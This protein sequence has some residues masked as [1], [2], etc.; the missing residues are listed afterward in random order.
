MILIREKFGSLLNYFSSTEP[1]NREFK[2]VSKV[3]WQWKS[4]S[5]PWSKTEEP[6]WASYSLENNY[7]IEKAYFEKRKEV[8][9]EDYII[10]IEHMVQKKKGMIIFQRPIRRINCEDDDDEMDIRSERHFEA[11]LPKSINKIFGSLAHFISFFSKRNPEILDLTKKFETVEK[12]NDLSGLNK[13][14]LPQLIGCLEE[15][16]LKPIEGLL[17]N[18]SISDCEKKTLMR[19]KT[20]HEALILLFK[21]D[22]ESFEEFY[23]MIL[24][25]YTMSTDLYLNLN[26]YLRN[27]SWS[28]IDNLLPSAICLCKAFFSLKVGRNLQA[29]GNSIIL[30]RGTAL[31]ELALSSYQGEAVSKFFSWNS[32]TSTST[33]REMA[34]NFMYLSAEI[35]N[36]R[37]PVLFIIEIPLADEHIESEYLKWID[38]HQYSA[39]PKEDEVILPPGSAF[40]LEQISRDENKRTTIKIKLKHELESLAHG[41]LI[42]QGALQSEMM[43]DNQVK[44]MCLEG[45]EL[46]E[47]LRSISGNR[48]IEKIE[49]CLCLFES[50]SLEEMLKT[51]PTLI[52]VK[53]VEFITC[54]YEGEQVIFNQRINEAQSCSALKV[55]I[56]EVQQ[57][58]QILSFKNEYWRS[59][60]TLNIEFRHLGAKEVDNFVLQGLGHLTQLT[61]LTLDFSY[62]FEVTDERVKNLASQG[63][64]RL[65]QL[66]SLNLDFSDCSKI[67]DKGVMSLVYEGIK[68]L[69]QLISLTL[70]FF[71]CKISVWAAKNLAS[72]GLECF[73]KLVYLS[74]N[75]VYREL[76]FEGEIYLKRLE[77]LPQLESFILNDEVIKQADNHPQRKKKQARI[78]G[79]PSLIISMKRETHNQLKPQQ[80]NSDKLLQYLKSNVFFEL[81]KKS[82]NKGNTN[83]SSPLSGNSLQFDNLTSLTLDFSSSSSYEVTNEGIKIM[84]SEGFKYLTQLAFL[85]L[86]FCSCQITD[87]GVNILASQG[88]KYLT[89][90]TSLS[91]HFQNCA[92]FTD[93]GVNNL[94][95]QGL[96][97]LTQLTSLTLSFSGWLEISDE[98]VKNLVSEGLIYLIQL[99][100]LTLNFRSCKIT[101]EG[102]NILASQ[103]LKSLLRL[104]SLALNFDGCFH[105][106]DG[107]VKNLA[108]QGLM[109]LTQLAFLTLDFSLCRQITDEGVNKL[110]SQGFKYLI[111]LTSL[112]LNF[113]NCSKVTD[114]GVKDLTLQGLKH[115]V[116][117]TS[118]TLIFNSC[119][120]ITDEGVKNIVSQGLKSLTKLSFLA[121][122]FQ[123]CQ[124]ITDEGVKNLA[125][126]LNYLPQL[127]SVTLKLVACNQITGAGVNDIAS[128][129]LK[130]LTQLTSLTLDFSFCKRISDEGLNGLVYHI[131]RYFAKLISLDLNF[132]AC[133]ISKFT[134]SN[135]IQVLHYFG[136]TK[137]ESLTLK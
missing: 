118:L 45:E 84:A 39:Q 132:S 76:S 77:S 78:F 117:L 108:S 109:H 129:G 94:A 6:Q 98:G 57:F 53:R 68:Y 40:Q 60:K 2:T 24:R 54:K 62:C 21:K 125:E 75:F 87:E 71:G 136:F 8:H 134:T 15:E 14:I 44:I 103:G 29:K 58:F 106:T 100:S 7:L 23:G 63:L 107:A 17:N 95:S 67:S 96:K 43:S 28:A 5:D 99:T 37:Y 69:T 92:K 61:S 25:S 3:K 110:A 51:L 105:V 101:E 93:M 72:Q 128:L 122:D 111:Q 10:S 124:G 59:L 22:F 65:I 74:L 20:R 89:Q 127:A 52:K 88:L 48:L 47:A 104:T 33:S 41:G 4:N 56:S 102:V 126:G 90:L 46:F 66:T 82:I 19:K 81:I 119:L 12:S 86:S 97:D 9:L 73:T 130:Y 131:T 38:I 1:K 121:L 35:E 114:E 64:K 133:A 113:S 80:D 120:K 112:T 34:E 42:M 27:E 115:L 30:Y 137:D 85:T 55:K 11:E 116:K 16:L 18:H 91:M 36:K 83:L 49:F 31:D 79:N 13:D 123:H 32:V 50:K 135:I 70:D 26:K